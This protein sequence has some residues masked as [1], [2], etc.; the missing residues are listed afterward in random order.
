[1]R[2][3]FA[4][5]RPLYIFPWSPLVTC[6]SRPCTLPGTCFPALAIGCMFFPPL[7]AAGYMFSRVSYW[8]H[9]F[10]AIARH[11]AHVFARLLLVAYFPALARHLAHVFRASSLL[12]A[13]PTLA[14]RQV[15]VFPRLTP[16]TRYSSSF[17]WR[18]G[19]YLLAIP[20]II[21]HLPLH[22]S[23]IQAHN[24][25]CYYSFSVLTRSPGGP[26]GPCKERATYCQKSLRYMVTQK[27][28]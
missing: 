5:Y 28:T 8:L 15:H 6:F 9:V 7:H 20:I 21:K 2:K 17:G 16:F 26:G 27:T 23:S 4:I 12:H 14:R 19:C 1:M 22:G 10:P 25:C 13:F 3:C 24:K 11:W 18:S